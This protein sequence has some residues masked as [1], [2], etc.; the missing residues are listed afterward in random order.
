MNKNRGFD[1][2][3]TRWPWTTPHKRHSCGVQSLHHALLL[4]GMRSDL[5]EMLG[6]SGLLNNVEFGHELP[7]LVSLARSCGSRAENLT[8]SK[9]C[10]LRRAINRSLK[11][12]SPVILGS[13]PACHWLVVAGFDG[14]GGY[15][16]IDS[17][18]EPLSSSWDWDEI[19]EWIGEFSQ[20][21]TARLLRGTYS[22]PDGDESQGQRDVIL[23]DCVADDST[24][25]RKIE[26]AIL[27]ASRQLTENATARTE[28]N[29]FFDG[30]VLA[31]ILA[32]R[33]HARALVISTIN[34][35]DAK[36]VADRLEG[37]VGRDLQFIRLNGTIVGGL[38]GVVIYG[39][40]W[41]F[42]K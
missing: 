36:E 38:L 15:V 29:A 34:A 8:T 23:R 35:W 42:G 20:P 2:A 9:P 24:V 33:P 12:G 18:D 19:Q 5:G 17:S 40:F 31:S 13:N 4:L 22:R 10:S 39:V 32:A 30:Q 7:L 41:F 25:C 16:W 1:N 27:S 6:K 11:I 26:E 3:Q 37:T 28:I 14:D 21:F